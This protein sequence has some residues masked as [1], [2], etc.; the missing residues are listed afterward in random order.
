MYESACFPLLT[1]RVSCQ[2]LGF[3]FFSKSERWKLHLFVIWR[4]FEL[5]NYFVI[6][7]VAFHASDQEAFPVKGHIGNTLD[8][9]GPTVCVTTA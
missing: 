8:H 7:D 9:V 1:H 2:P 5:C 6:R 3:F 4:S